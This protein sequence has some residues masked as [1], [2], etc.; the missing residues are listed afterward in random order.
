MEI[1]GR[2]NT[3]TFALSNFKAAQ[4]KSSDVIFQGYSGKKDYMSKEVSSALKSYNQPNVSFGCFCPNGAFGVVLLD[5]A[6]KNLNKLTK[7]QENL[8]NG[9]FNQIR[10]DG[11]RDVFTKQ[12]TDQKGLYEIK[13]NGIRLFFGYGHKKNIIISSILIK[14]SNKLPPSIIQHA[15]KLLHTAAVI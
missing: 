13:L 6:K 11:L 8:V 4:K 5:T 9:L 15:Y 2:F 7:E 3:S 1:R 10:K 14:K 12:I